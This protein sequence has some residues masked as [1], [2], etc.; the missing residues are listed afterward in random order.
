MRK[1]EI[2]TTILV[3]LLT[4][5]M[6]TAC[7]KEENETGTVEDVQK[8]TSQIIAVVNQDEGV[9]EPTGTINY[10][11][12]F[13]KTLDEEFFKQVSASEAEQGLADG[14]Y[15]GELLF[16]ADLSFNI[17]N[18]NYA[19]PQKIGVK[20]KISQ[21]VE[22]SASDEAYDR[23][24]E[25]YQTFNNR[26]SYAYINSLMEE[27]EMGQY[28]VAEIFRNDAS[29]IEAAK[30]LLNGDYNS[31]LDLPTLSNDKVTFKEED[32]KQYITAG[33][34][35]ADI[36]ENLYKEAYQ[37]AHASVTSDFSDTPNLTEVDNAKSVMTSQLTSIS[38]YKAE[39]DDFTKEDGI[40][41]QYKNSVDE[42]VTATNNYITAVDSGNQEKI[43]AMKTALNKALGNM[44]PAPDFKPTTQLPDDNEINKAI[45]DI[46]LEVGEVCKELVAR[47]DRLKPEAMIENAMN[48]ASEDG[49]QTKT[50]KDMILSE[51][52]S[53]KQKAQNISQAFGTAQSSNIQALNN[54]YEKNQESTFEAFEKV[55][56]KVENDRDAIESSVKAFMRTAESNSADTRSRLGSFESMLSSAKV[57]GRVSS[58]VVK[59][60]IQPIQLVEEDTF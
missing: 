56:K 15:A 47:S 37:T 7:T 58:A 8:S 53:F 59:F 60:L 35:Y 4:A 46:E 36:I 38:A 19:N 55:N 50:Y 43:G 2:A 6:L 42:L 25:A 17:L 48:S 12:E 9:E 27:I 18:L 5:V 23:I 45:V 26:L 11:E 1:K 21:E 49:A 40:Y 57:D 16:P 44:D 14:T 28:N 13:I 33:E 51:K 41:D 29:N 30:K 31:Q 52:A 24:I 54:A 10:S 20:Y 39:A 32:E 22:K 3:M 34:K